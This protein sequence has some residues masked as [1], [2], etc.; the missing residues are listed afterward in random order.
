M[1]MYVVRCIYEH[2][3]TAKGGGILQEYIALDPSQNAEVGRK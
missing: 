1:C 3:T 2:G